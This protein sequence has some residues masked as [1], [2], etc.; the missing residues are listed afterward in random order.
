MHNVYLYHTSY[1]SKYELYIW[2]F[3]KHARDDL[4]SHGVNSKLQCCRR[5]K[6]VVMEYFTDH[7]MSTQASIVRV[8]SYT[9]KKLR[10]KVL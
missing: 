1:I 4:I 10:H 3:I 9:P 2:K 6:S 8:G 5:D 7:E